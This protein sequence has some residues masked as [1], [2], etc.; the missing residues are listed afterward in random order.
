M[1]MHFALCSFFSINLIYDY[2][3]REFFFSFLFVSSCVCSV[4]S[5]LICFPAPPPA[6]CSWW[7]PRRV[8]AG[9]PCSPAMRPMTMPPPPAAAARTAAHGRRGGGARGFPSAPRSVRESSSSTSP[10]N[11]TQSKE[12][13]IKKAKAFL[14]RQCRQG[15]TRKVSNAR[16]LLSATR[17]AH[18]NRFHFFS[19]SIHPSID[20]HH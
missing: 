18:P 15:S 17:I 5:R 3:W 10:G 1:P 2:K 19:P 11:A 16:L 13:T 6:A 14:A 20:H 4:G 8:V 12:P 7:T 9:P